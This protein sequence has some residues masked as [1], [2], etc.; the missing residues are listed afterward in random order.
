MFTG[1]INVLSLGNK[2]DCVIDHIT[3]NRLD[4]VGVTETWIS[5][6]DKKQHV[7]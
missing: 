4:N 1:I 6:D 2:I 3:D 7:N 5:Y